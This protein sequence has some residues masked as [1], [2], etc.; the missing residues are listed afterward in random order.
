VSYEPDIFTIA[1]ESEAQGGVD[2]VGLRNRKV[3]VR[4]KMIDDG[5]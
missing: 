5:S 1:S 2:A 3:R 4:V